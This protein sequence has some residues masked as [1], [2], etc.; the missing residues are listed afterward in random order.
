[1]VLVRLI[2]KGGNNNTVSNNIIINSGQ[3]GTHS[4]S[5]NFK[6]TDVKGSTENRYLDNL[7]TKVGGGYETGIR[8]VANRGH[9]I[10]NNYI[11]SMTRTSVKNI[12]SSIYINSVDTFTGALS[13]SVATTI[14]SNTLD[15]S[16]YAFYF[17]PNSGQCDGKL[18][19][20][21][22]FESNLVN[23]TQ[24]NSDNRHSIQ[25][26]CELST[27]S[28]WSNEFYRHSDNSDTSGIS[29][30]KNYDNES[31]INFDKSGNLTDLTFSLFKLEGMDDSSGANGYVY[32]TT[33]DGKD[34]ADSGAKNLKPILPSMIGPDVVATT[35]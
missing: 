11:A 22:N 16:K 8:L 4:S 14:K 19:S 34:G 18:T 23:N 31:G 24:K 20:I 7:D 6:H 29:L 12:A 10:E 25:D 2:L 27:D 9:I 17:G 21:I 3:N 1:M 32:Y 26:E 35:E 28:T 33:R 5:N 13:D 15:R 30:N